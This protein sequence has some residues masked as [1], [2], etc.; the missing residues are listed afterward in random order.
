MVIVFISYACLCVKVSVLACSQVLT[1][2]TLKR[3]L[4][5]T[6]V[7]YYALG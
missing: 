4:N 6:N 7:I 5:I 3:I 1:S 2:K